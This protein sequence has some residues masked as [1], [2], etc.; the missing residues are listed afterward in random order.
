[1]HKFLIF[2]HSKLP[3]IYTQVLNYICIKILYDVFIS[4][5]NIIIQVMKDNLKKTY[6]Q[7]QYH[8]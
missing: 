3:Y 7:S 2:M 6:N 8:R 5:E 4:V 1:M